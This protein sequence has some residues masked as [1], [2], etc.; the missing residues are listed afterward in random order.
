MSWISVGG[1][2]ATGIISGISGLSQKARAK[3]LASQNQRPTYQ[4]PDE[5]LKNQ[6]MAE[7]QST[8]GLPGSTLELAK[9]NIQQQGSAA[10]SSAADRQGGLST[11]G[12][13][14]KSQQDANNQLTSQDAQAR[15]ANIQNLM[16][17]NQVLAGYKDKSFEYNQDAKYQENAAAIRALNEAGN[18]NLN[19]SMNSLLSGATAA[20][21]LLKQ[22]A[23]PTPPKDITSDV[24]SFMNNRPQIDKSLIPKFS[25]AGTPDDPTQLDDFY[26]SNPI[27]S[28]NWLMNRK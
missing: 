1:A 25:K 19:S 21:T 11:V 2:A 24:Q 9:Q 16:K 7:M 17:Q 13:I 10:L 20:A 28:I 22:P 12:A 3:K 26:T 15:M 27:Q 6:K 4:I 23:I 5:I 14:V 8:S 18:N